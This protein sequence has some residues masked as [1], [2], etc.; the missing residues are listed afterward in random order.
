MEANAS[1]TFKKEE[2]LCGKTL[3]QEL[4]AR[5]V[6]EMFLACATLSARTP[7][8]TMPGFLF[9]FLKNVSRGRSNA[10]FANVA[11]GRHGESR[12]TC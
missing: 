3:I 11:S 8:A 12:S 9:L 2:R 6:T 10:T 4:L 1:Y 7:D 5:V